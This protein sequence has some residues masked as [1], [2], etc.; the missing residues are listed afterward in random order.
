MHAE[1]LRKFYLHNDL[2]EGRYRALGEPVDLARIRVPMFVVATEAD[3]VS[4]WQSVYK[5]LRLVRAPCEFVLAAGGH[6]VAIVNPPSGPAASPHAA[7]R[8][9][10]ASAKANALLD[11]AQWLAKSQ[12]H[13]GSWWPVW[14]RWLDRHST[15][16][17]AARAVRP[18]AQRGGG[19]DAP[20][21]YVLGT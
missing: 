2:A 13:G 6:N 12:S 1:Y 4:P 18:S 20:G 17:I 21:D 16:K 11:T 8:G 3:H 14:N 10:A 5:I 15:G 19:A 7:W 9:V